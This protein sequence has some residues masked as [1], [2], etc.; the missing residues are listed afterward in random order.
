MSLSLAAYNVNYTGCNWR[1]RRLVRTMFE[2]QVSKECGWSSIGIYDG[3]KDLNT[4]DFVASLYLLT[5]LIGGLRISHPTH[6]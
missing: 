6:S 5:W 4:M 3:T 1:M 2:S